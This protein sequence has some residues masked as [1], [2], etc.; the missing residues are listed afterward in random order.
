M[1]NEIIDAY[2][3]RIRDIRFWVIFLLALI[4][5]SLL[6]WHFQIQQNYLYYIALFIGLFSAGLPEILSGLQRLMLKL[7]LLLSK[8]FR[9]GWEQR[10]REKRIQECYTLSVEIEN[11]VREGLSEH[12]VSDRDIE[13]LIG[14]LVSS[15]LGRAYARLASLL[16]DGT[17]NTADYDNLATLFAKYGYYQNEILEL[18]KLVRE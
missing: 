17:I 5:F 1:I 11:K 16:S 15:D 2:L 10:Q 6:I 12:N 3:E 4:L 8:P 14:L 18:S 13:S 7:W 9:D